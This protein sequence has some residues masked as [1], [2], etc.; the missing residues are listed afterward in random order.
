M[1]F[2]ISEFGGYSLRIDGHTY[3]KDNYGYRLF[4][5]QEDLTNALLFLYRDEVL[6]LISKGLCATV[7]TQ[8]SDVEDETNGMITYDR[9]VIKVDVEQMRQMAALLYSEIQK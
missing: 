7:L 3:G 5:S 8:L 6:P 2:V 1:P 4:Q 9:E